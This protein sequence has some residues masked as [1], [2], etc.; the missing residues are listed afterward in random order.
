MKTALALTIVLAMG[1]VMLVRRITQAGKPHVSVS[2]KQRMHENPNSWRIIMTRRD[3]IDFC[4]TFPATYEDYPFDDVADNVWTVM[5]HRAN[6]KSFA[7]VY[8][9][10]GKLCVNLKCEPMEAVLLRQAF[11]EVTPGYHMNKEH[12]NTVILGGDV[13]DEMLERMVGQSYDLIKP[14]ARRS[15]NAV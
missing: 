6:K 7:L 15:K 14:K 2:R 12:W 1:T 10:N 9:R 8:E 3:L 4:L 5:R 11:V 13:P